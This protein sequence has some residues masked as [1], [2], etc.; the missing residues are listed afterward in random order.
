MI[1]TTNDKVII[2]KVSTKAKP[3]IAMLNKESS[4]SGFTAQELIKAAKIKPVDSAQPASGK[5]AT[6]IDTD[7]IDFKNIISI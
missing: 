6:A 5:R 7:F 1:I 2:M 3:N 4:L